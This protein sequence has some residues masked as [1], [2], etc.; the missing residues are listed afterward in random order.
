MHGHWCS[1]TFCHARALD[2]QT[3][4][5]YCTH[6]HAH[7]HMDIDKVSAGISGHFSL[8]RINQMLYPIYVDAVEPF[9]EA[10]SIESQLSKKTACKF[11]R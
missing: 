11:S 10:T 5:P 1:Q 4:Q 3:T 2:G 9:L 6:T 7:L 8:H